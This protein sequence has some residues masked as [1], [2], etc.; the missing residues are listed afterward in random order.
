MHLRRDLFTLVI[1]AVLIGTT[2]ALAARRPNAEQAP[3]PSAREL[4]R[5][6]VWQKKA[7][8]FDDIYRR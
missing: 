6:W 3:Q 1:S 5:E 2:L 7:V 8:T 4:P